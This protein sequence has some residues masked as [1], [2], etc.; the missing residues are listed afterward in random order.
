MDSRIEFLRDA[1]IT[2][3]DPAI[4]WSKLVAEK[5]SSFE[6][7]GSIGD[8]EDS[9]DFSRVTYY[10]D[11]TLVKPISK[12]PEGARP[13]IENPTDAAIN[14]FLRKEQEPEIKF[15]Q[16]TNVSSLHRADL[17]E[18]ILSLIEGPQERQKDFF[19]KA[20]AMLSRHRAVKK[21]NR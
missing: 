16:E 7:T 1:A 20:D 21:H 18:L 13:C 12:T 4:D 5:A 2:L 19:E 8:L 10:L 17:N 3:S 6:L 9:K 14:N 15:D 11:R